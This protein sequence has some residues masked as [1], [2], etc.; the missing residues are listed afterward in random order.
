M[1][2]P[3]KT[4][5]QL[6]EEQVKKHPDK[7]AVSLG[8]KKLTYQELNERANQ[9]ASCLVYKGIKKENVVAVTMK[10][11]PE[12]FVAM[13]GIL[14]ASG[15]CLLVDKK[16][17]A[18]RISQMI[19]D[20]R[21]EIILT[22]EK[23]NFLSEKERKITI[24]I[25]KIQ[26]QKSPKKISPTINPQ[27]LA[28]VLYTSGS[29]GQPKG[30]MLE[31]GGIVNQIFHRI[32]FMGL[33]DNYQ[34]ALNSPISF[35]NFISQSFT[36]LFIG[37][38]LNIFSEEIILN[39]LT[40]L[41]K[42]Q[43]LK[44]SQLELSIPALRTYLST[45]ES[46]KKNRLGFK[47]L[48]AM[49]VTGEKLTPD[50]ANLFFKHY[51]KIRLLN[52]YGQTECSGMTLSNEIK[53]KKNIS[54]ILEGKATTNNQA[55]ILNKDMQ[56]Q[57]VNLPGELYISG[58][59]LARGYFNDKKRTHKAFLSHPLV[60]GERIYKTGDLAKMHN[61]GNIEILGRVDHQIK[62]RGNR[63]EPGEIEASL[64]KYK[65]IKQ[66]VVVSR[67][68]KK[69]KE[70]YLVAYLVAQ[71]NLKASTLRG[72]LKKTL[73]SY[74]IP[75]VFMRL[76]ELPLNQN[77][78]IDRLNLPEPTLESASKYEPPKTRLERK[79]VEIW[80]EVLGSKKVGLNDNLFDLGMNSLKAIRINSEVNNSVKIKISLIE[81]LK[82]S[83][84]KDIA[85]RIE[86]KHKSS[87]FNRDKNVIRK[88]PKRSFY[89]TS[90]EQERIWRTE[91]D[92]DTKNWHAPHT[93]SLKGNLNL[94]ALKKAIEL[95]IDRHQIFRTSF[96]EKN[97]S[98]NKPRLVQII[99]K[100]EL[101]YFSFI[102]LSRR[103]GPKRVLKNE[104]NK[105]I[106]SKDRTIIRATVIKT[107]QDNFL[108]LLFIPSI[109]YDLH[110]FDIF[111]KE[112]AICYNHFKDNKELTLPELPIK[113]TD[114]ATWSRTDKE[115][116][117]KINKQKK[118]WENELS[119]GKTKISLPFILSKDV[120]NNIAEN[121]QIT[122]ENKDFQKINYFTEKNNTSKFIF[123]LSAFYVFLYT[124]NKDQ[125]NIITAFISNRK[126]P[127]LQNV[128]GPIFNHVP[129]KIKIKNDDNF[130]SVLKRIEKKNIITT[131]NSD[132]YEHN[133]IKKTEDNGLPLIFN[134][135]F[136][137]TNYQLNF[138]L[139]DL[140]I[141]VKKNT[142]IDKNI[143]Y[144]L[145]CD[146]RQTENKFLISFITKKEKTDYRLTKKTLKEFSTF[147]KNIIKNPQ[148]NINS[149]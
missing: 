142:V 32:K 46:H 126:N 86:K 85:K 56:V 30:V 64:L 144:D 145:I 72:F 40:L 111:F 78:K 33:G 132:F 81:F 102:N 112:L 15:T 31:H 123:F 76:R 18:Q 47:K 94:P 37:A 84:I 143:S 19:K 13:L 104:N 1:S 48:K 149:K 70:Q 89:P 61:D 22:N 38:T 14:K 20:S 60:K 74:M 12:M 63:V 51:P 49:L 50:L 146:I 91:K 4:I 68:D 79:L 141:K 35:I 2:L 24:D 140:T 103:Q 45:I 95:I 135:L 130:L 96:L 3:N 10:R 98:G 62:I 29:T 97:A 58:K 73:P 129:T 9:L 53:F 44:I 41:K 138:G 139:S 17:P 106:D 43:Q 101:L 107:S 26:Y 124:L 7:V 93:F 99:N 55:Y 147:L 5:H 100:P 128:F 121:T 23:I 25:Q 127:Q 88:Y 87:S 109:T 92:L 36:P 131:E 77:G 133:Q 11:C 34:L 59:S 148:R 134:V 52:P 114:Y 120:Q 83:T 82:Y 122:I 16:F 42:A 71:K 118:F 21:T 66:C 28:F 110:S 115:Q 105:L 65:E 8:N 39:P 6:F 54:L 108:F 67:E 90:W 113:Y 136:R 80:Q 57:P 117:Q 27:N 125:E 75:L 137:F 119:T 116:L 69:A